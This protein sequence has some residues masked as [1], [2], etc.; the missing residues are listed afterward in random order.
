[1]VVKKKD[2]HEV[3]TELVGNETNRR[4]S[5]EENCVICKQEY[6]TESSKLIK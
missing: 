2:K 4:K 5:Q 6:P 3:E 1:M